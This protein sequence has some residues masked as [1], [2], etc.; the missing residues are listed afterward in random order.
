MTSQ[1]V[2]EVE[3]STLRSL[4]PNDSSGNQGGPQ[5]MRPCVRLCGTY[6]W[7]LTLRA[8]GR[9]GREDRGPSGHRKQSACFRCGVRRN[10]FTIEGWGKMIPSSFFFL[11]NCDNSQLLGAAAVGV[12]AVCR[13]RYLSPT[14]SRLGIQN[15]LHCQ[16][17]AIQ[18]VTHAEH[19]CKNSGVLSKTE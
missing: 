1:L 6:C 18:G 17:P 3:L 11:K 13:N 14:G 2:T 8:A 9:R 7:V 4:F 5:A 16:H 12:C 19:G 10:L 15:H